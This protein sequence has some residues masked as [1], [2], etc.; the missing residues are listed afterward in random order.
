MEQRSDPNNT[1]G[2]QPARSPSCRYS[3]LK[4]LCLQHFDAFCGLIGKRKRGGL[5]G[6]HIEPVCTLLWTMFEAAFETVLCTFSLGLLDL[7]LM[8]QH[9]FKFISQCC[10]SYLMQ[11]RQAHKEAVSHFGEEGFDWRACSPDRNPVQHLW[12]GLEHQL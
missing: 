3:L 9:T 2:V 1:K 4:P 11:R 5:R 7:C 8:L 10:F 6:S 12:D